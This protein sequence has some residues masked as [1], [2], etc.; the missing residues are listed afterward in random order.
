MLEQYTLKCALLLVYCNHITKRLPQEPV[1]YGEASFE[2]AEKTKVEARQ[3][4]KSWKGGLD[5]EHG[6]KGHNEHSVQKR[7]VDFSP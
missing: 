4:P 7:H 5:K 3:Q 6:T 2:N 1:D